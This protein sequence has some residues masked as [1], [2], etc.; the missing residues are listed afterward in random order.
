M[1]VVSTRSVLKFRCVFKYKLI[2]CYRIC[3]LFEFVC[4]VLIISVFFLL[5]CRR[6]ILSLSPLPQMIRLVSAS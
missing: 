2:G 3:K 6:R 1:Y 5:Y 4:C